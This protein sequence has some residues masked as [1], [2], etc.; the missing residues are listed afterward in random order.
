VPRASFFYSG[1]KKT[2][3]TYSP[4]LYMA[5]V[6]P[7]PE[8]S[9]AEI[10]AAVENAGGSQ[11]VRRGSTVSFRAPTPAAAEAVGQALNDLGLAV[12]SLHPAIRDGSGAVFPTGEVV[13]KLKRERSLEAFRDYAR[14]QGAREVGCY[15]YGL[16]YRLVLLA[17]KGTDPIDLANR[18]FEAGW[19]ELSQPDFRAQGRFLYR[20][21][22]DL[23]HDEQEEDLRHFQIP[24]AW[25]VTKG[26]QNVAVAV[27]DSGYRL[28]HPDLGDNLVAP[29]DALNDD[30]DPEMES[31][32]DFH[33]TLVLGL[34][35]ADTDNNRGVAGVGFRDKAI[36]VKIGRAVECF[37][38]GDGC[39]EFTC[40]AITRAADHVLNLS[41]VDVAAANFS[42]IIFGD[43]LQSCFQDALADIHDFARDGRGA[44][45]VAGTG[46]DGL[47][48]SGGFPVNFPF[49]LGAGESDSDGEGRE[50]RS[51]FG[52]FVDVMAHG[53]TTTTRRGQIGL[54]DVE[55]D[56]FS[57]EGTSA[58]TAVVSAVAGL[59]ASVDRFK[60]ADQIESILLHSA[61]RMRPA[62]LSYS[63]VDD[64][65]VGLKNNEVGFGRLNA[66]K[67]VRMGSRRSIPRTAY[68]LFYAAGTD[69]SSLLH[70]LDK[71]CDRN[72]PNSGELEVA[73]VALTPEPLEGESLAAELF[74]SRGT[75]LLYRAGSQEEIVQ[76]LDPI[77][78]FGPVLYR[79]ALEP[80]RL[81]TAVQP[82]LFANFETTFIPDPFVT[83][84]SAGDGTQRT[85][86]IDR[87]PGTGSL[88]LRLLDE[89]PLTPGVA[90]SYGF[91]HSGAESRL[92]RYSPPDGR[93]DFL[94]ID[95]IGRPSQNVGNITFP[96]DR[97][98][99]L[100]A[101]YTTPTGIFLYTQADPFSYEIA[102]IKPNGEVL[103]SEQHNSSFA[104]TPFD[105]L[106]F[107][108][109]YDEDRP[110]F[111]FWKN[112]GVVKVKHLISDLELAP[113][114][115]NVKSFRTA[116]SPAQFWAAA[117]LLVP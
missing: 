110:F 113:F 60:T 33:G 108:A 43:S 81:P 56:Y 79:H 66:F 32:E 117:A 58:S 40:S 24:E 26:D 69:G 94:A 30:D 75:P 71:D 101:V 107:Q 88:D 6:E 55:E 73:S 106:A 3:I 48:T 45:I 4:D 93:M 31:D 67:A 105:H 44:V 115:T 64:H 62:D 14:E 114:A 15:R 99:E 22:D 84:Y 8:I 87:D 52:Q 28:T 17:R 2:P 61:D 76:A 89:E 25:N 18:I 5:V 63:L 77:S 68:P 109:V 116:S 74:L 112:N 91:F 100:W 12:H 13:V 16:H 82:Y 95:R 21:N 54:N 98:L 65:V 78:G 103:R 20:P 42:L 53:T 41:G 35:G 29:Y 92:V 51:N 7:A 34:I 27:F 85:F 70:V 57:F 1:A 19:S 39:A 83:I 80:E 59:V 23:F 47:E 10:L 96:A 50:A 49:V 37:L 90:Y 38:G 102:E 11:A 111:F 46:N 9:R 97:R 36:P 72:W 104:D 86:R